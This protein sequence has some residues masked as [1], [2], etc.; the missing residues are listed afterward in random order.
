MRFIFIAIFIFFY[1]FIYAPQSQPKPCTVHCSTWA[2]AI[3]QRAL[4]SAEGNDLFMLNSVQLCL[5]A[6]DGTIT[7]T[8][9]RFIYLNKGEIFKFHFN[10]FSL[11][12]F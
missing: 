6:S 4:D 7:R 9:V 8:G 11:F 3:V 10:L 1:S 12:E 5:G 2:K